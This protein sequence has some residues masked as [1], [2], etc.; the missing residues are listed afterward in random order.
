[1]TEYRIHWLDKWDCPREHYLM[2]DSEEDAVVRFNN[3]HAHFAH[4][5]ATVVRVEEVTYDSG[6]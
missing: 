3:N 4:F 2:A 1:M 5:N 6:E